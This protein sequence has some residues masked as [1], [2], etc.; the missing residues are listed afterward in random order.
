MLVAG[1]VGTVIVGR[2]EDRDAAERQAA[3]ADSVTESARST[4]SNAIAGLGGS[5]G[6]VAADGS[7]DLSAFAA[8][9]RE[10]AEV[11]S[12]DAIAY[13]PVVSN[14]E[15]PAFEAAMGRTIN[16]L[17]GAAFAPA[18][19]RERYW[20]V[21]VITP[22]SA[23]DV[24][25]GLIGLDVA[26]F[27]LS[28]DI[29]HRGRDTGREF[30]T[31][32]IPL[33]DGFTLFF[34]LKPL[35]LPTLE[36][37]TVQGR[38]DAHAGFVI[39]FYDGDSLGEEIRR[40][41]PEGVDFRITDGEHLLTESEGTATGGVLR[42]LEVGGRTWTVR[43][44]DRRPVDRS[45]AWLLM[46]ITALVLVGLAYI[47]RRSS[48]SERETARSAAMIGRTADLGQ[49]LARAA[50]ADAV[51]LVIAQHVAPIF[52]AEAAVMGVVEGP[53]GELRTPGGGTPTG[54]GPLTD[55]ART[56]S[57]VV[58][59]GRDGGPEAF[60]VGV[61]AELSSRA[62]A[63]V[64]L[65]LRDDEGN[66]VA[67]IAVIWARR[68]SFDPTTMAGL[69]AVTEL[70]E[71]TLARAR[72]T[73]QVARR[74]AD[75]AE[76][77]Q[78]LAGVTTLVGMSDVIT[79]CARTP[80]G[81]SVAS[82]GIIDREAGVLRAH[83][84]PTVG[85][86]FSQRYA[87]PDLDEPL[88]FTDAARTGRPV[89]LPDWESYRQRYP[90]TDPDTVVMG[91]GARAAL[92]LR[93]DEGTFGAIVFAWEESQRFDD[94]LR[95]TLST[96]AEIVA[97]TV[98]R[99]RLVERQV[100][101][102]R[103]SR[104]LAELAQGLTSQADT[105]DVTSYLASGVL[106]PL[107]AAHAAVALVRGDQLV[108]HYS[109]P[110][111]RSDRPDSLPPTT[112][113]TASTP[114]TDAAT[115]GE[116]VLLANSGEL[117]ERYP[118][119]VG[120][121]ESAGFAATANLALRDRTG[122]T[123]GALGIAWEHPTSFDKE[124][125]DRLAT[126]AGMAAQTLERAQL[127][128]QLRASASRK[129]LLA[130]LAQHLSRG[131]TAEDLLAT[132]SSRGGGPVEASAAQLTLLELPGM[133]AGRVPAPSGPL[134]VGS[135]DPRTGSPTADAVRTQRP[136]LL[137]SSQDVAARYPGEV[138]EAMAAAGLSSSAHLPL[139]SPNGTPLGTIA[140][141]WSEPRPIDP[142][143]MAL[144]R[145]IGEL[146]AQTLE[147]TRLGE[148]EHRLVLSL[149]NRVV[150]PLP[151]GKD[152]SI[153]QRYRPAASHVGMGG[154][155]F[156]GIQLDEHR[157]ALV[158]GDISGHGITAVADMIQL[159]SIIES[160]VRAGV[161]VGEVFPRASALLMAN[162][163]DVTASACLAVI[164]TDA[165]QLSYVAAGHPPPLLRDAHGV[166]VLESGRQPLLGIPISPV[167]PAVVAFPPGSVFAAYTDGL[168]ERRQE[169]ID[170]SIERLCTAFDDGPI[171][172]V[173]VLA[174]TVMDG[175]LDGRE[176]DDDVALVLLS[177]L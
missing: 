124:L 172:D 29:A 76:L 171:E 74:A 34:I 52:D 40:E 101:E 85:D 175:C 161:P 137:T 69:R 91:A 158:V 73:D 50:D 82:F 5:A 19:E 3:V 87:N 164:D 107:D 114:L 32:A 152:L 57:M 4:A 139:T 170:T 1:T 54:H 11:S 130:D 119:L 45:L 156:E 133:S 26:E 47:I 20:P 51:A 177:H 90:A 77:A 28:E 15:R 166:T 106:A 165:D 62:R 72:F 53:D 148:A 120:S 68:M 153:A 144:M 135:S 159:R 25:A 104:D 102:A 157:Y 65:P 18:P 93:G 2:T 149:Q 109:A 81:A 134:A 9:Q 10:V 88:A 66:V 79:E 103:H 169:M 58:S 113:L 142:S 59:R 14:A 46:G 131:R 64:G 23:G 67:A 112:P 132:V 38:R 35:Y 84:G 100:D 110:L 39:S 96:I 56:G 86:E 89:F 27:P 97:L 140:F 163:N 60:S 155:W 98:Q 8:Y 41:L 92:P 136:V 111:P 118:D 146:C 150:T 127:V 16:D 162:G 95:S 12:L 168:I 36:D 75:L 30:I 154:D 44:D 7:V 143:V 147:R 123:F 151:P 13:V 55:A 42:E 126:I 37:P 31:E 116:H 99:A 145:T 160:L 17:V 176:P 49:H 94:A 43:V 21:Q 48:R 80:V 63:A 78:R 22:A 141:G 71:Q 121:W 167:E 117:R 174:G 83:H 33:S 6:L 108:R 70:C 61:D 125:R 138:A 105:E 129:E 173:D 115:T 122:R 128:D 24:T